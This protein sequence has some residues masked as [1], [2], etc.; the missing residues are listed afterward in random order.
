MSLLTFIP[1]GGISNLWLWKGGSLNINGRVL[2]NFFRGE[3]NEKAYTESTLVSFRYRYNGD[4]DRG[5]DTGAG[6]DHHQGQTGRHTGNCRDA[7]SQHRSGAGNCH[8]QICPRSG[9]NRR[10]YNGAHYP[11]SSGHPGDR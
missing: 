11:T 9:S 8:D 6:S 4:D 10:G 1:C 2:L 7:D 5:A 3:K